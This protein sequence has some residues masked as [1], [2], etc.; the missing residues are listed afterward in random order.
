[1]IAYNNA[2]IPS[3]SFSN[4]VDICAGDKHEKRLM[5]TLLKNYSHHVRPSNPNN[6]TQSINVQISLRLLQVFELVS[7]D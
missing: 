5:D 7:W 6:V 1:M 2:N 4:P 3:I